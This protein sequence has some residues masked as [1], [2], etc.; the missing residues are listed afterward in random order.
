MSG[1]G[2]EREV[3]V[4]ACVWAGGLMGLGLV[5]CDSGTEEGWGAGPVGGGGGLSRGEFCAWEQVIGV[6]V[7]G[8]IEG[9]GDA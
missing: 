2:G 5:D 3:Y 4:L 9:R 6:A 7:G 1:L 8:D